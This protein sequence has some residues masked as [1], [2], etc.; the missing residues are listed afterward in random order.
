MPFAR[1]TRRKHATK[2]DEP[3]NYRVTLITMP[4]IVTLLA[5]CVAV[6][7]NL[8][9]GQAGRANRDVL[10]AIVFYADPPSE[11]AQFPP[12]SRE[13]LKRYFQRL[14]AYRPRPRPPQL[15]SEMAMVYGA[16]EAYEGKLVAASTAS[17]VEQLA[18]EY[19]D[20][21][22]PCY[23]WEGFHD[24]PEREALFAQ[25]YLSDHPDTPFA[26]LLRVLA[27]HRWL[28]VAEAYEYQRQPGSAEH[29]RHEHQRALAIALKVESP[30]MRG[31]T[32]ELKSSGR[33][34][35][36]DPLLR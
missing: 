24:C 16:R 35:W 1:D 4:S 9:L 10:D 5:L 15:G 7:G 18:Q 14:R 34:Y 11:V 25:R 28:C 13:D 6:A 8:G 31:A 12:D 32:D 3:L 30:L 29:A 20:T 33:C 27:A 26:D 17:G 22:R 23:E 36:S 21:L 2:S 19:V